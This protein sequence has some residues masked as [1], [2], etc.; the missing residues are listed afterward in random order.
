MQ[1]K[2]TTNTPSVTEELTLIAEGLDGLELTADEAERARIVASMRNVLD[3]LVKVAGESKAF[4]RSRGS[5]WIPPTASIEP[6]REFYQED[7]ACPSCDLPFD[8]IACEACEYR[9][10]DAPCPKCG[11]FFWFDGFMCGRCL[12]HVPFSGEERR[13]DRLGARLRGVFSAIRRFFQ[14]SANHELPF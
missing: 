10:G 8:G 1:Q 11:K 12:Y 2:P 7:Q 6:L 4:K 13:D 14:R 3:N 5:R 9:E